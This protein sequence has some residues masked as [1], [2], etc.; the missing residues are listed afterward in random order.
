MAHTL[1]FIRTH[2]AP[3][4]IFSD[5]T[6]SQIGKTVR[7]ILR[8]YAIKDF[9]CE[10]HHQHQNYAERQIQEVKKRCNILM[11]HAGTPSS[12]WLLCTQYTV[13]I[14]NRLSS[15][16]LNQKP[17]LEIPTGQQLDISAILSSHWYQ[18][19]YIKATQKHYPS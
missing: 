8:M 17:P 12:Y 5:S 1:D 2:D 18:P 14:M 6:R 9:R 13:Y 7:E 15:T 4:A 3:N 10:S 19:V 16:I 11:D